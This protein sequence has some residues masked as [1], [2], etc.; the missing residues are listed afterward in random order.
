MLRITNSLTGQKEPFTS[1]IPGRVNL[2]VCGITP[3]DFSHIGH[4]R[5]YVVFDMIYRYLSFLG[6][7][8]K[9]CRNFT[10]IDDKLLNKAEK[11]FGDA[12]HYKEIA[13]RYIAA[14]HQDMQS[15]N[16]LAPD[17]EPL[18]TETIPQIIT[19]VEGLIANGC[20]YELDG[21]IY[22]RVRSFAGYG[23]LSKQDIND[24][25]AGARIGVDDQKEDPLDFALW[26]KE[27][28]SVG[29][30]SPWGL[31]RPG[32]HIECSAMAHDYFKGTVDIHGGGMDL[33]FPHHENEIAQSES[34]YPVPF[35]NY[36][37][38]NAF[39]RINKEKMSKSLNNF[40]TLK[41]I[42]KDFDPMVLRFYF[43]KHY[44]RGPLDFSIEDLQV[45]EKTYKR[46]VHFFMNT[47]IEKENNLLDAAIDF[48][49][50]KNNVTVQAMSDCL[51]D[52]FNT[53]GLFGVLFESLDTLENDEQAKN[54]VKYFLMHVMG[55]T[56]TPIAEKVVEITPEIQML[57][58]ARLQARL[59]KQWMLADELR[60]QLKALGFEVQDKKL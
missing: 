2:Y 38:H 10:D 8:V 49:A 59:D 35:V 45:A 44:Y 29:Y 26:K 48:E 56:L 53:S 9:Y 46:L 31:G 7:Q 4:G 18:V 30:E 50:I 34:L 25:R 36:W 37:M 42:L 11:E 32:W 3:Y 16:C 15:L 20:A 47:S 12:S 54:A 33:L 1:L 55:L 22:F 14:Y 5:C 6:Y 57:L 52:D 58:D 41:D 13:G 43:M 27:N 60:D 23:K 17:H 19:F 28:S 51:A 24:L 39:V 40:F 21:S